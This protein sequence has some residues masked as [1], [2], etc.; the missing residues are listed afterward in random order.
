MTTPRQPGWYDDPN[1]ANAQRYWDGQDWTPHRQRKPTSGPAQP[2]PPPPP[3]PPSSSSP[4]PPPPPAN[5]PPPPPPAAASRVR[6][7]SIKGGLVL[8]GLALVL[9]IAAL[10]AGRVKFGTFLPG[11]LLVAAVAVIV[12]IFVLRSHRSVARKAVVVTAMVLVVAAAIPASSKVVYPVYNHYFGHKPGQASRA[13]TAGPG[14][15]APSSGSGGG[16]SKSGILVATDGSTNR[17]YGFIDPSSGKYSEVASFNSGNGEQMAD[18]SV[19]VSPDFT[20]LAVDKIVDGQRSAGW[21]DTSG[22][23]TNVTPKVD[24]GAF[25]GNPPDFWST[26]FDAAGNFYYA[27]YTGSGPLDEYKLAPGSTTHAQKAGSGYYGTNG[28]GGALNYDGSLQVGCAGP[29]RWLGPDNVISNE[30]TQLF[31]V[32]ITGH[33]KKG[34]P[35]KSGSNGTALLPKTNNVP[36]TNPVGNHDGTKVAFKYE[37]GIGAASLYIVVADGNSQPAKVNLTNLTA[38]RLFDMDLLRWI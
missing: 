3:P 1:D 18:A 33:D 24:T 38:E 29:I 30:R 35:T 27:E 7:G 28:S 14:A 9:V 12:A 11:I 26:G 32:A 10:V 34:C 23:F 22:K 31:K 19:A 4:P 25:G 21:I 8:A 6:S 5:E 17:S 37:Q 36:V 15:G 2:P 16:T 20:K 13:G